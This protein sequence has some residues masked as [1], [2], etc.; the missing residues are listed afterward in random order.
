MDAQSSLLVVCRERRR[1]EEFV[2]QSD[3]RMAQTPAGV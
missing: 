3:E 1:A 2:E